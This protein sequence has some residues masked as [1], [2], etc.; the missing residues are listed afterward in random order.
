MP[1]SSSTSN[2][3]NEEAEVYL[4]TGDI[5][6]TNSR[7]SL[8]ALNQPAEPALV[9]KTYRNATDIPQ[10]RLTDDSVFLDYVVKP[11]CNYCQD[12]VPALQGNNDNPPPLSNVT[13][14]ACIA[15]AGVVTH[16][17]VRL[18]N[19]QNMLIC[20]N[21]IQN[22]GSAATPL[23]ARIVKCLII[24]DFVAQGYGCL[25]L[26]PHE[27]RQ[28]YG[29]KDA[30]ET[31]F[32]N[33]SNEPLG[34]KVCVGAGTGLGECYL[35]QSVHDN[36]GGGGGAY[37]C[38]PSE[39]GHVEF[40]PLNDLEVELFA[41]LS[42]KLASK[43]RISVERVV[44]GKGLANVYEFLA[45]KFPECCDPQL[46]AEFLH[47]GDQQGRVVAVEA[48]RDASSLCRRAMSILMSAYGCEV[49]SAAIK[50]IPT[51]G[52]FV[53]GG[54]TPKN[55]HFMEGMHSDFMIAYVN[56]GRV[57][58]LLERVP[59]FAVLTEDLGNRGAHQAAL[60]AYESWSA[61][62]H[63]PSSSSSSPAAAV[64]GSRRLSSL[65]AAGGGGSTKKNNKDA[66]TS[67]SSSSSLLVT[68]LTT[69][70]AAAVGSI[71]ATVLMN[72]RK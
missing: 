72:R 16:N 26:Q 60:M 47:A 22:H 25:T 69:A 37:S 30:M 45:H 63:D 50:W 62:S 21:L 14:V 7:M 71:V 17:Q 4:L 59:L 57:S 66:A 24:N 65:G 23:S 6:G 33:T 48:Q 56:K 68:F 52:L 3:T 1:L 39:G 15:S 11:F 44:S 55:L 61:A 58:H 49:G 38:F 64:A 32:N 29:P 10:A 54:L 51:G 13:I 70:A 67:V 18:T 40:P 42:Q 5:G 35:T 53:T 34:P 46:H 31:I 8:Y 41:Y 28:L 2:N 9:V 27:V 19:L 36:K 20:G 12:Q 43:G